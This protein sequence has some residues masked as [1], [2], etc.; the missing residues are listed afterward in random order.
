M[1]THQPSFF[2]RLR[3]L[4]ERGQVELLTGGFYEPMIAFI[5]ETDAR[6]Q[7]GFLTNFLKERF[8]FQP[9]GIW[10]P[11]RIWN[12]N[13]PKIFAPLGLKYTI[14]DD[15]L[16]RQVGFP[17]EELFG[18]YVTEHE[19]AALC[20][21]PIHK[22]LRYT[23]PFRPPHET[24]E[25]LRFWATDS[26]QAA[27]TYADDGEKFGLWPGTYQS[28]IEE[29][30]LEN[31]IDQIEKNQS[32]IHMVTF[33]EYMEKFPPLGRA[34]LPPFSYDEMMTWTLPPLSAITLEEITEELK[35]EGRYGKYQPFLRGG[36]WENFFVKYVESNHMHKRML[37]VSQKVHECLQGTDFSALANSPPPALV[38]LWKSQTLCSYWHGLFGGIY[39]SHLRHEVFHNLITAERLAEVA[40]WGSEKYLEKEVLDLDK[41]LHPEILLKN[42]ELAAILKP[43]YGGALIEL[44]FRPKKFN[45]TNVLTRRPEPYHRHLKKKPLPFRD[46][47]SSSM[48]NEDPLIYDWYTRYSFLD[49]F[50]G[51][52]TTFDQFRRC[53]YPEFGDFVN[54]PYETIDITEKDRPE[55]ITILLRRNGGLWKKEGRIP[56]EISKCFR[57]FRT[58]AKINVAYE[59]INPNRQSLPLWFGVE[60]SFNLLAGDD[61]Q[62]IFL[63][64]GLKVED[65]RMSSYGS[66]P[67]IG[68]LLLRDEALGFQVDLVVDPVS[69][70]WRFPLE[71]ISRSERG[72]E[73]TYQG[74]VLLFHW[75]FLLKAQEARYFSFT[76]S[77]GG[78]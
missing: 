58:E 69:Q 1:E 66:I 61:P 24:L 15:A 53:Q 41:D 43:D 72:L 11:E 23:I 6:G 40:K 42:P 33:R 8:H 13:F 47:D 75:K 4:V 77:C 54:Q 45:I 3:R 68:N 34:Y 52:E 31:F 64:P 56:I 74:T 9:K 16:F 76:L 17:E 49:H 25:A 14:V 5:P 71:T 44:D 22:W 60:M 46:P 19:G 10:L 21:F 51:E 26:G 67:R 78:I 65:P 55:E 70:L 63:F 28:V 73:K 20:L 35:R 29:G 30:W 38:A 36:I 18:Y 57:F 62:R 48:G 7:I 50:L 32:W 27:A 2:L 39:L 59:L 12:T 37:Y